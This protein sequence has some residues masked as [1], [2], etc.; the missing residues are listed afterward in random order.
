M[1]VHFCE[2]LFMQISVKAY[3]GIETMKE[4]TFF[5]EKERNKRR[6]IVCSSPSLY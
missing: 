6:G 3:V 2:R 4:F 1:C 5:K